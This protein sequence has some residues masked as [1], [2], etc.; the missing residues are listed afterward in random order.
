MDLAVE[1]DLVLESELEEVID[2][3]SLLLEVELNLLLLQ[4]VVDHR[5]DTDLRCLPDTMEGL[6]K[7]KMTMTIWLT[8]RASLMK[9]MSIATLTDLRPMTQFLGLTTQE[10]MGFQA[11]ETKET[12]IIP[13]S[14]TEVCLFLASRALLDHQALEEEMS[15]ASTLE[16]SWELWEW[17]AMGISGL[18]EQVKQVDT[19]TSSGSKPI[20]ST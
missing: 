15:Q 1:A 18:S 16:D 5:I 3:S 10:A 4:E 2:L 13:C 6:R 11:M 17:V 20:P 9:A 12:V 8:F 14:S 19:I 7:W